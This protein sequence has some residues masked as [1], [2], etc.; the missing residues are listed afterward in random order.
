M[1]LVLFYKPFNLPQFMLSSVI[2]C[3]FTTTVF[4]RLLLYIVSDSRSI[5]L[6][7]LA[8][9]FDL[10]EL[11]YVAALTKTNVSHTTV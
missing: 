6:M 8:L 11:Q 9:V 10:W 5:W 3:W 1:L 4:G 2:F 7:E